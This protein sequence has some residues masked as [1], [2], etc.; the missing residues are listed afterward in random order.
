MMIPD[1]EWWP[2]LKLDR[3]AGAAADGWNI[4]VGFAENLSIEQ[5]QMCL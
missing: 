1:R 2:A 3:G 5:Q 4:L